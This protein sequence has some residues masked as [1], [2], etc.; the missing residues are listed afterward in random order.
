MRPWRYG[1]VMTGSARRALFALAAVV[2]AAVTGI[3][4][5]VGDGVPPRTDGGILAMV[6]NHGHTAAWFLLTVAFA[7]A[8]VRGAWSTASQVPAMG[9]LACYAAFLFATFVF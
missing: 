4:A 5:F 6:A 1:R 7:V 3:F 2:A 8:A 9:G